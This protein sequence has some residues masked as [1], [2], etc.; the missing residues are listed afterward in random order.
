MKKPLLALSILIGSI[1]MICIFTPLIMLTGEEYLLVLM[2]A[3][4]L[5]GAT[6]IALKYLK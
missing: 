2:Y 5:I 1:L 3:G 4:V 6:M